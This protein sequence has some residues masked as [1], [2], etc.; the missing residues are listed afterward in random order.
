M[1]KDAAILFTTLHGPVIV[2]VDNSSSWLTGSS[3]LDLGEHVD[4]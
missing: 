1:I 2:S 3:E 4:L